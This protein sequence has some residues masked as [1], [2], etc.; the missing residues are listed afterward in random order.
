MLLVLPSWVLPKGLRKRQ[1]MSPTAHLPTV[2]TLLPLLLILQWLTSLDWFTDTAF[3]NDLYQFTGTHTC[4]HTSLS[5]PLA[6]NSTASLASHYGFHFAA[7]SACTNEFTIAMMTIILVQ[8]PPRVLPSLRGPVCPARAGAEKLA[9]GSGESHLTSKQTRNNV[10]LQFLLLLLLLL[11]LHTTHIAPQCR[12]EKH[13]EIEPIYHRSLQTGDFPNLTSAQACARSLDRGKW[14]Q[15]CQLPAVD[16]LAPPL[17]TACNCFGMSHSMTGCHTFGLVI[18]DFTAG[19]GFL[20]FGYGGFTLTFTSNCFAHTFSSLS[21][22]RGLSFSLMSCLHVACD[23]FANLTLKNGGL[24]FPF[25]TSNCAIRCHDLLHMSNL[26]GSSL[27]HR[28]F[29]PS[30]DPQRLRPQL[31]KLDCQKWEL[32]SSIFSIEL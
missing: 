30:F 26:H 16:K 13:W 27:F 23:A 9:G 7:A 25:S 32:E 14:P 1:V 2:P 3:V 29:L 11:P 31:G 21:A 15:E 20:I 19:T 5:L 17:P 6:Q 12:Q 24:Y 22:K 4:R 18:E 10:H 8:V 28:V